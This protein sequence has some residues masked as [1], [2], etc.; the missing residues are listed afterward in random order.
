MDIGQLFVRYQSRH[1][2]SSG[3]H[4]GVFGLVNVLG[5][6]G[7]LT[8]DEEAFRRDNNAWYDAAYPNPCAS[9]PTAYEHPLA[10]AWFKDPAAAHL[11]DRLPGYLAILDAHNV[12]W[13]RV[14]V[15]DPG[16]VT[17]DDEYQ[18]IAIPADALATAG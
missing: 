9:R 10:V 17:Y 8:P 12:A 14:S 1:C 7:M 18:V 6:H 11:I 4:I 5:R 13:E 3:A 2:G 16:L 15:G